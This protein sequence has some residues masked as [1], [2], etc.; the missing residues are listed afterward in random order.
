M[1]LKTLAHKHGIA[2]QAG[3]FRVLGTAATKTAACSLRVRINE[4]IVAMHGTLLPQVISNA[5]A[6]Q[7]FTT[8]QS[9][10]RDNLL[11]AFEYCA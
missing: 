4:S 11:P 10:A 1:A 6:A 3:P 7:V 8:L 9:A 5:D 2:L